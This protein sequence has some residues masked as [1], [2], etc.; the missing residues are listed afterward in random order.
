MLRNINRGSKLKLA[1]IVIAMIIILS[2]TYG[3]TAALDRQIIKQTETTVSESTVGVAGTI[4]AH[5]GY[6]LNSI[7]VT[8]LAVSQSMSSV[9]LENPVS[10]L[11]QYVD[12]TPFERIE[13]INAN[14]MNYTDA[15][16][17]FDASNREYFIQ[18][19][20]GNTGVWINFNPKYD[21][22]QL[23]NFYTPLYYK[24][25]IVGVLTGTMGGNRCYA[26]L[27]LDEYCEESVASL[28]V[29]D[30][31]RIIAGNMPY[32]MGTVITWDSA[33]VSEEYRQV[34]LDAIDEAKGVPFHLSGKRN[35]SIGTVCLIET[36]GWRVIQAV[37]YPS[38][39]KIMKGSRH[40]AYWSMG[41]VLVVS[42][43][44]MILIFE[45]SRRAAKQSIMILEK[46]SNT[47]ELTGLWN[48]HA[49]ESDIKKYMDD[50]RDETFVY[51][52][53]DVNG[54]KITNDNLGH[55]A[56]DELLKGA[57]ECIQKCFGEYGKT[58]RIGGDEFVA[59]IFADSKKLEE[60]KKEFDE[61][62]NNWKGELV[63]QL[64]ISTGDVLGCEYPDKSINEIAKI[65]DDRMYIDKA[66]YYRYKGID[67]RGQTAAYSSLCAL[68][69]KILEVDLSNDTYSVI[70][71]DEMGYVDEK[72]IPEQLS[73]WL[74]E[75]GES[76]RVHQDDIERYTEFTDINY[77]RNYF[78]QGKKSLSIYYRRSF[79]DGYK[80]VVMDMVPTSTYSHDT[81]KLYLYVKI[82]DM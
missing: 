64:S 71:M 65:A 52:A 74:Y 56:G 8:S 54:L 72:G 46:K 30:K 57:A 13:Y 79:A 75:F 41:I 67:R 47:D 77:L 80:Q 22:E 58:Y 10:T 36:T 69:T 1:F 17:P 25:K 16:E 23:L 49:Y 20:K 21:D 6:A 40:A 76:G 53:M 81:Q 42:I 70:S 27:L 26:P 12:N 39:N 32:E 73:K 51:L 18:G 9:E 5:V 24:N 15:G 62:V 48:R 43:M 50:S 28:L 63:P 66:A 34:F 14:G 3:Y 60:L 11:N 59:I 61:V 82:L 2:V 33:N 35:D 19:I 38:M 44:V 31:N 4:E 68:Y 37:P 78:K 55:D 45:D 7:Q 29:D